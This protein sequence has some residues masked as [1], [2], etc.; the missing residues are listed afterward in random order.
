MTFETTYALNEMTQVYSM[1]T[2]DVIV[3][4]VFILSAISII[5]SIG[6]LMG[7]AGV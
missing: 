7:K 6:Y 4:T 3:Y 2:V 1:S 5:W